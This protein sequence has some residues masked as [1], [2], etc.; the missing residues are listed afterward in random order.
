MNIDKQLSNKIGSNIRALRKAFG[1]S[2]LDLALSIGIDS[3]STISQYESFT[4]IPERDILLKIARHYRITVNELIYEDLSGIKSL[5]NITI[6]RMKNKEIICTMFP[7]IVSEEAMLD[8]NFKTAYIIH[9]ELFDNF[10]NG[11]ELDVNVIENCMDLYSKA[12]KSGVIEGTANYLW[13]L[14]LNGM[15][16]ILFTPQLL[17]IIDQRADS[18]TISKNLLQEV[19]LTS[20]DDDCDPEIIQLKKEKQEYI[21]ESSID[22]LLSISLLKHSKKYC[23]LGD[24]YLSLCYI[25][26]LIHNSSNV[27]MNLAIG[28]EMMRTFSILGNNYAS[29]FLSMSNIIN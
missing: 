3:V 21:K 8:E 14:I 16:L 25:Y 4:R 19:F 24:Y 12:S 17:S 29:K 28:E 18:I 15:I 11:I 6:D 9:K 20:T 7:I 23:D 1:E 22:I 10:I 27:E 26:G 5:T 2:Q 13:W